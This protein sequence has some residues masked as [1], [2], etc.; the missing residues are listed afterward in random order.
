MKI[1]CRCIGIAANRP[2]DVAIVLLLF[3]LSNYA[4]YECF[5]KTTSS[6]SSRW[7]TYSDHNVLDE[8]V[9]GLNLKKHH[10]LSTRDASWQPYELVSEMCAFHFVVKPCVLYMPAVHS[11]G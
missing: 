9:P 2:N 4:F 11:D 10:P 8:K 3:I 7:W 6:N 1:F 5:V